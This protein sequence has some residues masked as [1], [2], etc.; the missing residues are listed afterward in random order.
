MIL[1]RVPGLTRGN[2]IRQIDNKK[3]YLPSYCSF[4]LKKG[5]VETEEEEEEGGSGRARP[6]DG[7]VLQLFP[8]LHQHFL[9]AWTATGT[10]PPVS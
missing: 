5:K 4:L 6:Q 3:S 2:S 8:A 7:A 1:V 10:L 9:L